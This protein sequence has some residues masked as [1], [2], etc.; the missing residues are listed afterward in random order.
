MNICLLK[1]NIFFLSNFATGPNWKIIEI[2]NIPIPI[3]RYLLTYICN[4]ISWWIC[5]IYWVFELF[6]WYHTS[7]WRIFLLFNDYT[8]L[9]ILNIYMI[10]S[11][12]PYTFDIS[13][14]LIWR[15]MYNVH[16]TPIIAQI[17]TFCIYCIWIL[18]FLFYIK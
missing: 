5:V 14:F 17:H 9:W 15:T 13:Y 3:L 11:W 12:I 1:I 4:L 2:I 6:S 10:I 8:M 7:R 18:I 16:I